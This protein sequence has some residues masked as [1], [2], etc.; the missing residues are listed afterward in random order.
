M[1]NA[2]LANPADAPQAIENFQQSVGRIRTALKQVI[3]GQEAVIE[4]LL[5]CAL[6]GSHALLV[7]APGLAKTLMVKSLASIFD[8]KFSRVQFTPDLMP[9][10]ITGTSC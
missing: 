9:S 7:G 4:Q 5:I 1:S 3:V 2:A 8:W 10:D 6:T